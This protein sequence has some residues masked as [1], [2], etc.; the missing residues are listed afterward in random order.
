MK[1]TD[2][3][4]SEQKVTGFEQ[5][6][7]QHVDE[8]LAAELTHVLHDGRVDQLD[9]DGQWVE[10]RADFFHQVPVQLVGGIVAPD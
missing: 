6:S 8:H 9:A 1:K 2:N 7:G 4:D 10:V 3:N 5:I